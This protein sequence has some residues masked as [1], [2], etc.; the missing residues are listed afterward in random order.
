MPR[1]K[2]IVFIIFLVLMIPV[3]LFILKPEINVKEK[4]IKFSWSD[5]LQNIRGAFEKKNPAVLG[6][7]IYGNFGKLLE[8]KTLNKKADAVYNNYL[9]YARNKARRFLDKCKTFIS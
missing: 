4:F 1:E 6:E 3:V 9:A 8:S 5:G 7:K 2:K